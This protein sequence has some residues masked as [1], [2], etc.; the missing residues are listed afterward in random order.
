MD[1][2]RANS[3]RAARLIAA[4]FKA[5]L[6]SRPSFTEASKRFEVLWDE[7]NAT[8]SCL[9]PHNLGHG[10]IALLRRMHA[11]FTSRY[12][13]ERQDRPS[14]TAPEARAMSQNLL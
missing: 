3:P 14:K 5:L 9:L 4:D 8:A 1:T 2:G 6:A 11:E 7:T 13:S 10:Y 12:P